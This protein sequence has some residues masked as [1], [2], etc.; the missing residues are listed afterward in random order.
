M[1]GLPGAT[2]DP[3][4]TEVVNYIIGAPALGDAY[5]PMFRHGAAAAYCTSG[6]ATTPLATCMASTKVD[7]WIATGMESSRLQRAGAESEHSR[8]RSSRAVS[9]HVQSR[10]YR[11]D[12]A[13]GA[14]AVTRAKEVVRAMRSLPN[15]TATA[16]FG[17]PLLSVYADRPIAVGGTETTPRAQTD[18]TDAAD[19]ADAT[20][21]GA[22]HPAEN[23]GGGGGGGITGIAAAAIVATVVLTILMCT[24][25]ATVY[26]RTNEQLHRHT[27]AL[28]QAAEPRTAYN[29]GEDDKELAMLMMSGRSPDARWSSASPGASVHGRPVNPAV[30]NTGQ[31]LLMHPGSRRTP[32]H[33]S[34][35]P[36]VHDYA[37][38]DGTRRAGTATPSPSQHPQPHPPHLQDQDGSWDQIQAILLSG[39]AID[40]QNSLAA[41][42]VAAGQ[43]AGHKPPYATTSAGGRGTPGPLVLRTPGA[44][45]GA[46]DARPDAGHFY[47]RGRD[48]MPDVAML[49]TSA[50]QADEYVAITGGG[51]GEQQQAGATESSHYHPS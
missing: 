22:Q 36:S 35:G 1:A 8:R 5:L 29:E 24:V 4:T 13:T 16:L 47:P 38:P 28:A 42:T 11:A 33:T 26:A 48:G 40:L 14:F 3:N 44:P 6:I 34:P 27:D 39:Y 18:A 9:T 21:A 17:H 37:R 25:L 31:Y 19:A 23:G 41:N 10:M 43:T 32:A 2:S 45:R 12:S 51:G 7:A 20:D 15:T 46:A 50:G 49:P 30:D